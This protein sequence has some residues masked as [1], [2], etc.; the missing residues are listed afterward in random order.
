[1]HACMRVCVHMCVCLFNTEHTHSVPNDMCVFYFL[2]LFILINTHTHTHTHTYQE[3]V[4]LSSHISAEWPHASVTLSSSK[5]LL[6]P[7]QSQLAGL[8]DLQCIT[9]KQK[10][11]AVSTCFEN[12]AIQI[13][14][15]YCILFL[16]SCRPY[17][18][19]KDNTH[20]HTHLRNLYSINAD[21]SHFECLYSFMSL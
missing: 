17:L 2:V 11:Q 12:R 6:G 16:Y 7:G 4:L 3:M 10:H 1:M 14:F 5:D 8:A 21:Q 15:K 18:C 20:T 9:L 13:L 19:C